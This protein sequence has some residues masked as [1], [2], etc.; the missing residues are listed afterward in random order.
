MDRQADSWR[1]IDGLG[2]TEVILKSDGEP[3]IVQVLELVK[4]R[5][6]QR[7]ILQNP[8][9]YDPASN[10]IAEKAVQEIMEQT[11]AVK[12]GLESHVKSELHKG[13]V[14][15]EWIVE[16]AYYLLN[17]FQ[18]GTDGRTA[19]QRL[20]LIKTKQKH[21]E[22]GEQVLIVP[23]RKMK[24]K[25]RAQLRARVLPATWVGIAKRSNEHTVI[26]ESGGPAVRV[27]TIRR[28][29][30]ADRWDMEA[31]K[32]IKARPRAPNTHRPEQEQVDP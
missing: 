15:R 20:T 32:E 17:H 12:L 5:R 11:R 7:T 19:H 24:V 30:E 28:R 23:K 18:V 29:P 14:V 16:H 9:A 22:F 25:R 1:Y 26:L 2:Y 4:R 8:P 13:S 27:R 6:P 3:S 21:V 31:L 10:G